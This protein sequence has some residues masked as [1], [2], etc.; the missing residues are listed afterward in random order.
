MGEATGDWR[1]HTL[2][3]FMNCTLNNFYSGDH[4]QKN[5]MVRHIAHMRERTDAYR[6]LV[7][8]PEGKRQLEKPWHRCENNIRTDLKE[9][10]WKGVDWIDLV[11]Y[12]ELLD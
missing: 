12:R 10:R 4:I 9:I 1:N 7:L 11:Q 2:R 3:S 6:I 5:E 8:K